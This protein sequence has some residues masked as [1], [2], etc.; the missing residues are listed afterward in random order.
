MVGQ[1]SEC[2]F[3]F[4]HGSLRRHS[5]DDEPDED[6][7]A[8]SSGAPSPKHL[9]QSGIVMSD[10]LPIQMCKRARAPAAM[11]CHPPHQDLVQVG[12]HDSICGAGPVMHKGGRRAWSLP[13]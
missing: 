5:D 10:S 12:S 2:L 6:E 11:N 4:M 8:K 3:P 13:S 9:L 1:Y 7:M